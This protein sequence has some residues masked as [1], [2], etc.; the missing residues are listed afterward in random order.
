[1]KFADES[2]QTTSRDLRDNYRQKLCLGKGFA[3]AT[4]GNMQNRYF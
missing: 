4:F 1:M 3:M 2:F